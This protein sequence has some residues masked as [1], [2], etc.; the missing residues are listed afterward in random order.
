MLW[1][2]NLVVC[3]ALVILMIRASRSVA[4][5]N[6]TSNATVPYQATAF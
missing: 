6:S 3:Y 1:S 2:L 5:W 4:L